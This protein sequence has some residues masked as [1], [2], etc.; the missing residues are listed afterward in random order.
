MITVIGTLKGG[1]GKSTVTFNLA[2]WLA[3]AERDVAVI[4]ADPQATLT[5][6]LDVR[7]EEGFQPMVEL[8]DASRMQDRRGLLKREEVLI[9]VGTASMDNLRLAVSIADRVLVPVPPSQADIWSTQRFLRFVDSIVG[10]DRPEVLGFI[11][12]GDTH[13]AVRE[14][15]EAAAA[16]VSLPGIRYLKPRLAQRTVY[17][18]SFSEGLT[19]FE[20]EP[21]GKGAAEWNALAAVLYADILA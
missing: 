5:D 19:V 2:I 16:L 10:K 18:R 21:R 17:R 8:L 3:M 12:R 1:S 11:N 20:Q 6:V 9:D 4:D 13:R 14:S 15:D 7:R